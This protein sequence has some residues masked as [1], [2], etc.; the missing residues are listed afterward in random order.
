MKLNNNILTTTNIVNNIAC[1]LYLGINYKS[2]GTMLSG[3]PS[4]TTTRSSCV[5]GTTLFSNTPTKSI[6]RKV[7]SGDATSDWEEL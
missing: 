4:Q 7:S 3:I 5:V 2:H 1:T 6:V